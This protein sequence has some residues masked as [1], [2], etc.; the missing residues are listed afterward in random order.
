MT[1]IEL[2]IGILAALSII[3]IIVL[4][5]LKVDFL[6]LVPVV[7]ALVGW[8]IGKKNDVVLGIFKK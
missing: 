8:L 5:I 4:A 2:I 7:T 3:G 6:V 1:K